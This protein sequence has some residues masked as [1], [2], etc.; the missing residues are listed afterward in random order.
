MQIS[1]LNENTV[2]KNQDSSGEL[3]FPVFQKTQNALL[4]HFNTMW[5]SVP[6]QEVTTSLTLNELHT[7]KSVLFLKQR[8]KIASEQGLD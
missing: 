6:V 1:C 5:H 7:I 8:M 2:L 3:P 4:F